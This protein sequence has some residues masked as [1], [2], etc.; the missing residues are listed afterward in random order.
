MTFELAQ[1]RY[2]KSSVK[3]SELCITETSITFG[4]DA[5]N[6]LIN[7]FVEVYLDYKHNRIGFKST[8]DS[9]TGFKL[10]RGKTVASLSNK[11]LLSKFVKGNYAINFNADDEMLI[12]DDA[13]K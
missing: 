9:I 12:I 11:S 8:S 2:H 10:K 6:V 1:K 4:N 13:L 7:N 5:L 3:T